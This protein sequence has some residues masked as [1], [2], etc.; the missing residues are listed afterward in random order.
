VS[1]SWLDG[2]VRQVLNLLSQRGDSSTKDV[3]V[4]SDGSVSGPR[5]NTDPRVEELRVIAVFSPAEMP[6]AEAIRQ[7]LENGMRE[8]QSSRRDEARAVRAGERPEELPGTPSVTER[9]RA[10]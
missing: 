5:D 1:A 8:A 3:Y 4:W 10:G 9:R 6:S 7:T 2:A